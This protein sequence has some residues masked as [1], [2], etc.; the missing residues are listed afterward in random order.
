MN[1][2]DNPNNENA[3]SSS[4][5]VTMVGGTTLSMSG[6]AFS[7][8]TVW[9]W[10]GG[11]GSSGGIS[12]AYTIPSWQAGI[13]MAANLGSTTHRN[14]PDVALTADNV[15]V[16]YGN[17]A[18]GDFGGTSCAA[19]LWAGFMALVNQQ[20]A[21]QG[22]SAV[23]FI[24]PA[25]YAIGTGQNSTYS[26]AACFHDTTTGNNF[27]SDSPNAFPAAAGYD[28]C[29]GWG[30]PNGVSLINA[31][32]LASN[33]T[34]GST[35]TTGGST[36]TTGSSTANLSIS[37]GSG[38]AF[39]GVAGGPFTPASEIFQITNESS[40]AVSWSLVSTSAWLKVQTTS[41]TLAANAA[42]NVSVSLAA[43]AN[44]LKMGSYSTSMAFANVAAHSV[45]EI[46]VTV[47]VSQP[48]SVS[49]AEGFAAVGTVG[50]PFS[51]GSQVFGITN[52]S[53]SSTSWSLVNTSSW[54]SVSATSGSVAAGGHV[55]VTVSLSTLAKSLKAGAYNG[56]ISFNSAAGQIAVVPFSLTVVAPIVQNGGFE[57]GTFSGWTR[58]GNAA[59]TTVARVTASYVHSGTY[60]T[61]LGPTGSPGY[62]SQTM[63]TVPGQTYMLSLWL[64]NSI[65]RTPNWFQVQWNGASI[66]VVTNFTDRNWTNLQFL[67]TATSASSGLQLGFQ[68][69]SLESLG[70]DDISMTP[71]A[72][73]S[74]KLVARRS[75]DF[76]LVWNTS[77]GNV[78]QAQY[79]TNLC[80]PDWINLG[81][82]TPAAADTLTL[83]DTNALQISPQR[84]YRLL[85]IP[86]P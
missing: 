85:V 81:E 14:I 31:L 84:F 8:E 73:T 65:G 24:N 12:T 23:G 51:P 70:L 47:Q 6:A 15:A 39:S 18:S 52:L 10:G 59:S 5:Y 86:T 9:N 83:T 74:I 41:G 22:N 38:S 33:G 55:T 50:G 45:Q 28:L 40:F 53:G 76:Q 17:G 4:P 30:T 80:Q 64:R 42:V 36:N 66:F 32:S 48:M 68:G 71:V 54:L 37:P 67:V 26:Y 62:I 49:P 78:Y 57:T 58:S 72:N 25:V 75:D 20:A 1:G 2:V 19:P 46:P 77:A 79:K 69:S 21:S 82:P 61:D 7:S 27:S 13:S 16:Y 56:N 63:T 11:T 60:G 34:V 35:N 29:T 3:P 43:T 44:A